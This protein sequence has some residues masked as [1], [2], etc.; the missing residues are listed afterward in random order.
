MS[1]EVKPG[2]WR[3]RNGKT[4]TVED[5]VGNGLHPWRGR[6]NNGVRYTWSDDG[7]WF[8]CSDP[9]AFDLIEYL[10]PKEPA[11]GES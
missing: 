2:R 7:S 9:E 3:L 4:A 11:G 8:D 10:G 1:V 5:R 6:D